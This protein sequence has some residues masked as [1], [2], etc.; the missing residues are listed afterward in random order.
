MR[1]KNEKNNDAQ[2]KL[3]FLTR[4]E[5]AAFL[6]ISLASFDKIKDIEK[7]RYGR[8]SIRFSIDKLREYAANHTILGESIVK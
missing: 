2:T 4:R 6:R 5:S 7:I 3:E 8:K 1:Q